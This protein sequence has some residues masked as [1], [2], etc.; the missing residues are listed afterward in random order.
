MNKRANQWIKDAPAEV[1][2]RIVNNPQGNEVKERSPEFPLGGLAHIQG[3]GWV[4]LAAM[5]AE[6]EERAKELATS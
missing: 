2:E 3:I 6:L 1:L 4:E 5:R